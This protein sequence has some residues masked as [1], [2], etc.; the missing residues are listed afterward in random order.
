MSKVGSAN[1]ASIQSVND[2]RTE[3]FQFNM[4]GLGGLGGVKVFELYHRVRWSTTQDGEITDV[5]SNGWVD[6]IGAFWSDEGNVK[7]KFD[8]GTDDYGG[9]LVYSTRQRKMTYA[10]GPYGAF[11]DRPET[12]IEVSWD[13]TS[14]V[15]NCD[16]DGLGIENV[17][18]PGSCPD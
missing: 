4:F 1:T 12:T 17:D 7:E 18:G 5:D 13:R 3:T 14:S 15:D 16:G 9:E 8:E 10:G 2:E 11:T 6:D